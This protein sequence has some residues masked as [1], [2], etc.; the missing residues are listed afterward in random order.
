MLV[1]S[2]EKRAMKKHQIHE[3]QYNPYKLQNTIEGYREFIAKYP[4]NLFVNEAKIQIENLE[5]AP[6]EREDN[7]EGYMEFKIRYPDNRHIF[8][9]SVK[10]E[11]VEFKRYEKMDTIEAYKEFLSKYPDSTLAILAKERLQELE[12]RDLDKTFRKKYGIDLLLYR[13]NLKRLKKKLGTIDGVN[14]G[15]FICFV[16]IANNEGKKYF[17][18]HLIYYTDLSYLDSTSKEVTERFFDPL[19]SKALVYL[20]SHFMNK[21]EID[22]FSFDI[23]SSAHLFYGD[24]KIVCEYY[25]PISEVNLFAQNK[26][27]KKDL[28]AQSIITSPKKVVSEAKPGTV[29]EKPHLEK[30]TTPP[31]KMDGFSIMTMVNERGRGEDYIISRSWEKGRHSMTSIEK[32]KN[33]YGKDGF[34]NKSIIRYIDPPGHYGTAIL[35]WNYK[36]REKAFWYRLLHTGSAR[37]ANTERLRPPAEFDFNLTDYVDINVGEE[38]HE[39]LRSE[40]YEG[41][42]C[43]VVES[44]PVKK[45]I[46]YGKRTSWIDQRYFIP[47]KTE[48]FDKRGNPWKILHIEWQ[49]KFG[50]WFW[51]KAVAENVQTGN[52][53]FI[54]IEDVRINLRLHDRDFTKSGLEQKKHG[55]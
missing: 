20:D 37:I 41:K 24:R 21:D 2:E 12:F 32:R 1:F 25:F 42:I 30:A 47:L 4:K 33:F 14:L 53:T 23:S 54:T 31:V 17:H 9:A 7:I 34:I 11:Q 22:G 45:D 8:K 28:L 13:L 26:L 5:F 19:V 27:D 16:S 39:L 44:I 51:K 29:E 38:R 40:G 18:T 10:I 52:K 49:N 15:D 50:F 36:D 35:I 6:Y 55:F 46:R 3:D 43:Y 48:Y